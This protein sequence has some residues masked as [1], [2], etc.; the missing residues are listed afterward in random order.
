M[1]RLASDHIT[2]TLAFASKSLKASIFA[3]FSHN[4]LHENLCLFLHDHLFLKKHY[5]FHH[6]LYRRLGFIAWVIHEQIFYITPPL[7]RL[8]VET[9]DSIGMPN[10]F[11]LKIKIRRTVGKM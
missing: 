4:R 6:V 7:E 8:L 9:S 3:G 5:I 11:A 10:C 2:Q 1:I